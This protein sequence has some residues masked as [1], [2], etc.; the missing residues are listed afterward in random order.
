MELRKSVQHIQA[1]TSRVPRWAGFL[2]AAAILALLGAGI[3]SAAG[4][5]CPVPLVQRQ[6]YGFVATSA[7]WPQYFDYTALKAGWVVASANQS[8]STPPEGIDRA[9][10]IHVYDGYQVDPA[11]LGPLVAGNPG[12]TWLVGNEP[13]CINDQDNVQPEEYARIYH[14]LYTFIKGRDRTSQVAAGGIVQPTPLRLQYLDL[15]L[16]AYQARYGQ[17]MPMDVWNIH[18]AILNE[19]SCDY[20]PGNCWGAEI[21]PGIVAPFG[22]IR[23]IDDND[24]MTIFR[25]QIWAFRQW[26]AARGYGGYPLIV[27]EYGILMPD[28]YGFGVARVNAFMSNT[29]DFFLN[30]TDPTLGDPN[31]GYRLVQRWAWFSLDVQPWDPIT[32]GFNGNLFDP[33]TK[34]ITAY[35]QHYASLTSAFP[36]LTYVDLGLGEW[37]VLPAYDLAGPGQTVTRTLQARI[38]N[39]GTA[40]SGSFAVRLEYDGPVSG[41]LEQVVPNLPHASSQW[42][43]FTLADLPAGGYGVSLW[44]DPTDQ[45][46]ESRECN[47]QATTAIVAPTDRLYLPVV[48]SRYTGAMLAVNTA[49]ADSRLERAGRAGQGDAVPGFQEFQVP[50][51]ASFP[52]QIALDAQGR[53]WISE[54]DANK[55]ARFDPQTENW[56]QYVISTT[57]SQP[58]G[59]ALDGDGNVWFAET[60]GDKIGK[61]EVS[62]GLFDEY[63]VPAGSQPWDVAVG[64][65]NTIWFTEKAGNKIGKLVPA[66]GAIV[67]YSVPTGN[68]G[69]GWIAV[70]SSAI[71]FT[72]T[73]ADKLG[74]FDTRNGTFEEWQRPAG[75]L[76]REVVL[77]SVGQPWFAEMG[78]NRI[79][80]LDPQ[81][82]GMWFPVTV[83]TANGKPYGIAMEGD[84]AVWF[85]ERAANKLGRYDARNVT[86]EYEVPTPNSSPT[87][88]VVDGNACAWYTAPG[89]NQIGRLCPPL[90]RF[91]Y[92][93]LIAKTYS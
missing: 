55:I 59:L 86:F 30:T 91:F 42:L 17:A 11:Q 83:P 65:D 71:W 23:T 21:P 53:V 37:S 4:P 47:N 38:V 13:D 64:G 80:K 88:I 77:N 44:I 63:P 40:D 5:A 28:D 46:D 76:P 43:T 25:N 90:N 6:R 18:N 93:P 33:E 10:V 50:T 84:V 82:W 58:W 9:S 61:L 15:I 66:T 56:E 22:E 39:I 35:G 52:A 27:T 12:V 85:T 7:D 74:R 26:M 32:G 2:V 1:V 78:G 36:P 68:A 41:T 60:A 69:P 48:S 14:D 8:Y 73:T 54:R 70:R 79:V 72:E 31:D 75:S 20:D 45:V 89:A 16:A 62:S 24:N 81:T 57:N 92:L 3:S 49:P 87:G 34:A 67:S 19:V 29:F 51:T